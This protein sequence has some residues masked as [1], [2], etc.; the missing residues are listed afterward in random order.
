MMEPPPLSSLPFS[1]PPS[2]R[3]ALSLIR[4]WATGQPPSPTLDYRPHLEFLHAK[5]LDSLYYIDSAPQCP[6]QSFY[7]RYL[8]LQRGELGRLADELERRG[9]RAIVIKGAELCARYYGSHSLA[10]L[11]DIDILVSPSDAWET[12]KILM[13]MGHVQGNY[14]EGVLTPSGPVDIAQIESSHYEL[15]PFSKV[16][17]IGQL[18]E[19]QQAVALSKP[20]RFSRRGSDWDALVKFDVHHNLMM[21]MDVGPM[22]QRA[23]PSVV[24]PSMLTLCPSDHL[25]FIIHRTYLETALGIMRHLRSLAYVAPL[26]GREAIDWELLIH[27]ASTYDGAPALYYWLAFLE[28][29]CAPGTLPDF[30]LSTLGPRVPS[31]KHDMGWQIGKLF[32]LPDFTA[33]WLGERHA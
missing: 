5:K 4:R 27:S 7:D 23:V 26:F 10:F 9:I 12:K 32:D 2:C 11:G 31:G 29:G 28:L 8:T 13:E 16:C 1:P 18:D 15:F 21:G 14:V 20:Y 19:V 6:E 17:P 25:W 3:A 22:W 33:A 30:V 24:S